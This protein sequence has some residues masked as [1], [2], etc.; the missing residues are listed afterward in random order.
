LV[1]G[2]DTWLENGAGDDILTCID[3]TFK[4]ARNALA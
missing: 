4:T 1:A 3:Q 2:I